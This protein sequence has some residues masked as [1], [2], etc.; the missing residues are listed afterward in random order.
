M[1][2]E[3]NWG[4]VFPQNEIGTNAST[5]RE[6]ARTAERRGYDH[7]LAFD[8]VLSVNSASRRDWEYIYDHEDPFHEVMV[9]LGYLAG[10]TD[11]LRLSTGI[12]VLPQR[13]APVVAK[14]AAE[15]DILSDGRLRLGIGVGWNEIE[16]EALGEDFNTRGRRIEE[17]IV[18][19]IEARGL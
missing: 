11:R 6:C 19:E 8:H 13:K 14:Q 2:A 9:L 15:I 18:D 5:V 12:L 10:V 4:V 16:I 17:Q 7:L 3:A 1:S